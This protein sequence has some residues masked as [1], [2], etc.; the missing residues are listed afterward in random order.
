MAIYSSDTITVKGAADSVF[1]TLSSPANL[2]RLLDNVPTDKIPADKLE[3]LKSIDV[4]ENS[5]TVP[6]GPVGAVK[7]VVTRKDPSSLIQYSAEGAPVALDLRLDITPVSESESK[8]KVTIDI[9]IPAM[10]KPMI[11]GQIQKMADQLG[12]VLS[13]I[14]FA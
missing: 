3:M 7:F 2:R 6:G 11:G 12:Q 8:S 5:L 13:T 1:N 9:A 4:T 14:P 10:L